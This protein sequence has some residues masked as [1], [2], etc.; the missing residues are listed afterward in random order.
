M[1]WLCQ[2]IATSKTSRFR[3][4]RLLGFNNHILPC[5]LVNPNCSMAL[6]QREAWIK[7]KNV[8]TVLVCFAKFYQTGQ[9]TKYRPLF[10]TCGISLPT[11]MEGHKSFPSHI[12]RFSFGLQVLILFN[13]YNLRKYS[14]VTAA[15]ISCNLAFML[16]LLAVQ[17]VTQ[18]ESPL[19]VYVPNISLQQRGLLPSNP[20]DRSIPEWHGVLWTGET[21]GTQPNT[22]GCSL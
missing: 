15:P 3:A 2:Q 8:N 21:D 17:R 4:P 9:R 14:H 10:C 11:H 22:T 1:L 13:P 18:L 16:P 12:N 6:P 5:S 19:V 7:P 20:I